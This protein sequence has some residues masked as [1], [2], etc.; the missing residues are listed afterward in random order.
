METASQMW[1]IVVIGISTVFVCLLS[2]VA[3]VSI[4]K[5]L[6]V[7]SPKIA[8]SSKPAPVASS[9]TAG[10]TPASGIDGSIMAAI[11]GAISAAS[12]IKAS[13]FRIRSIESSGHNTPVWGHVDRA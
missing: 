6:F 13:A 9:A 5:A 1:T 4:F 7:R 3:M 12:G 2:L 8:A 10:K 11:V